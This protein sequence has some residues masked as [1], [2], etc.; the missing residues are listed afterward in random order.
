MRCSE[1]RHLLPPYL[2]SELDSRTSF[3]IARHLE[4]CAACALRFGAE[5]RFEAALARELSRHRGD[6][7]AVFARALEGALRG[8]ARE[9]EAAAR[10]PRRARAAV[11][12]AAALVAAIAG[13]QLLCGDGGQVGLGELLEAVAA[14]HRHT[15]DVFAAAPRGTFDLASSRPEEIDGFL[16]DSIGAPLG[17][18]ALDPDWRIEGV[19]RCSLAGAAVGYVL[20]FRGEEPV[21]LLVLPAGAAR[22]FP[23]AARSAAGR[24]R[25]FPVEGGHAVLQVGNGGL[26]CAL[27]A[28]GPGPLRSLLGAGP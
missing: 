17:P 8:A 22:R 6:E 13:W 27:G 3:E 28:T 21:S 5:E 2:D 4:D 1:A 15:L 26:R 10:G 11:A 19:R 7:A 9:P 25:A 18:L 20:L 14:D 16:R 12:A 24:A 23:A